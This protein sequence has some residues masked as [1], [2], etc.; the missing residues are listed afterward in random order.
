[1]ES[2]WYWYQATDEEQEK[3]EISKY[4]IV[5]VKG[6]TTPPNEAQM[7][8]MIWLTGKR[9]PKRRNK[10]LGQFLQKIEPLVR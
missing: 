7:P 4:E 9:K 1:M 5:R 3:W 8:P 6:I 2:G 10:V